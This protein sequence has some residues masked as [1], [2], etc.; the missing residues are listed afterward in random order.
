MSSLLI[1][2]NEHKDKYIKKDNNKFSDWFTKKYDIEYNGI[3]D[4]A[5]KEQARRG[6]IDSHNLIKRL[7]NYKTEVLS[8]MNNFI[9]PF[10]NNLSEQDL[11]MSKVK[12]K[13][14][15]CF[16]NIASGDNFCKIRSMIISARK[17][18]KNIFNIMQEAFTKNISIQDL[19]A[20]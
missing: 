20:T 10:T 18:K 8:F 5:R 12:Q 1:K 3:L 4:N 13:I 16:R 6:T 15:G 9:V 7:T 14:S 11:R 17:N 19:T 2:I